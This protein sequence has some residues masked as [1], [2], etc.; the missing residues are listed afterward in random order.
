MAQT[1]LGG[2][3]FWCIEAALKEI[4]GVTRVVSGYA[5]GVTADPSYEQVCSGRTGHAEVTQ[6]DFDA[7]ELPLRDLLEVFFSVHDPTTKDRQGGDVGTQYRSIIL[8]HDA[9]QERIARDVIADVQELFDRPIVTEVRRLDRFWPA[10]DHHQEYYANNPLQGYCQA[11][12]APKLAKLRKK[13]AHR[14][15]A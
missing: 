9:E 13:W 14:L 12:I 1:T 8:A 3:C 15:K 10:E 11:V 4:E 2:G 7:A 5:G 6:V